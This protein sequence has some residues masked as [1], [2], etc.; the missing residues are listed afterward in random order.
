MIGCLLLLICL[1][2]MRNKKSED[3]LRIPFGPSLALGAMV[4]LLVAEPY[5]S[6]YFANIQTT[7]ESF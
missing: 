2:F 4:Y 7:L 5:V 6:A 3:G 1:P